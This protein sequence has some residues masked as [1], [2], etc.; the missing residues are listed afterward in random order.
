[1]TI[2]K[3]TDG[4]VIGQPISPFFGAQNGV[5]GA[6]APT[7]PSPAA[8]PNSGPQVTTLESAAR[9]ALPRNLTLGSVNS[10]SVGPQNPTAIDDLMSNGAG[11]QCNEGVAPVGGANGAINNEQFVV[12]TNAGGAQ[13]Q[14]G[15]TPTNVESLPSCPVSGAT[16]V[17]N[18]TPFGTAGQPVFA[19]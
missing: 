9:G 7:I 4:L 12:G 17:S 11:N 1:M 15:P 2:F 8:S 3:S 13:I 19:G 5:Q 16:L 6:G 10:V 14:N 18:L